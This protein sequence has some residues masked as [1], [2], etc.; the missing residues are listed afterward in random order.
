MDNYAPLY[1]AACGSVPVDLLK[2]LAGANGAK[3]LKYLMAGMVSDDRRIRTLEMLRERPDARYILCGMSRDVI[4]DV[5]LKF[6][7]DR[8]RLR[9]LALLH[10]TLSG[11][12]APVVPPGHDMSALLGCFADDRR[13]EAVREL[14]T[15]HGVPR[16]I[17]ILDVSFLLTYHLGADANRLR[18]LTYL[19]EAGALVFATSGGSTFVDVDLGRALR[20]VDRAFGGHPECAAALVLVWRAYEAERRAAIDRRQVKTV[21]DASVT[22]VDRRHRVVRALVDDAAATEMYPDHGQPSDGASSAPNRGGAESPVRA[23]SRDGSDTS[24][25]DTRGIS[26]PDADRRYVPD[27]HGRNLRTN[28]A[29]FQVGRRRTL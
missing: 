13:P 11:P 16:R 21:L 9:A 8:Y 26:P 15:L 24:D 3:W 2:G 7:D 19:V 18:A 4:Y 27:A 6:T 12:G 17:G 29:S 23:S 10:A 1:E 5:L 20:S 14:C 28:L 25:E 22:H